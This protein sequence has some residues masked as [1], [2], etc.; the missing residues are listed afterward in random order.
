MQLGGS[1]PHSQESTTCPY[2]SHINPLLCPSHFWQEQLVSF[3]VGLRTYQH[4]VVLHSPHFMQLGGSLPHSQESTTC[5]YPSHINPLL[6]P[7]HFWQA[8]L[9]SF[10]AGLRTYQHPI[11]LSYIHSYSNESAR[12]NQ[13]LPLKRRWPTHPPNYTAYIWR[14]YRWYYSDNLKSHIQGTLDYPCK[15]VGC[16]WLNDK[17]EK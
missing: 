10:L 6:C 12:W 17:N 7:S 3:L 2:P 14:P 11:F 15:F 1:L 16:Q 9:V 5:P 13:L 4:P 8:Q